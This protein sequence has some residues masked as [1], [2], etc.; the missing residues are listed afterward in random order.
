M[1]FIAGERRIQESIHDLQRVTW[2]YH[3]SSH[4]KDI[5]VVMKSGSF[6]AEAV[7]AESRADPLYLIGCDG[8]PYACPA[9]QDPLV[10]F[11]AQNGFRH[12]FGINRVIGRLKAVAAIVDIGN[13]LF[14]QVFFDLL[15]QFKSSVIT[16]QCYHFSS[17]CDK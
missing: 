8:D 3:S 2:S 10:A 9:D 7:G 16:S 5:G 17:S 1:A 14:V 13:L 15:F 4:G 12:S 6:R 11:S